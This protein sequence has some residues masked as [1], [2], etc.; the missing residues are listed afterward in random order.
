M[1]L[2]GYNSN[3][4]LSNFYLSLIKLFF[5][6]MIHSILRCFYVKMTDIQRSIWQTAAI[7]DSAKLFICSRRHWLATNLFLEIWMRWFYAW[8][9]MNVYMINFY[10][11]YSLS[12]ISL[13]A[14]RILFRHQ[15]LMQ[16]SFFF[17]T[18]WRP[19]VFCLK[20]IM[21]IE[22][23]CSTH[24]TYKLTTELFKYRIL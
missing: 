10:H 17:Y 2:R 3:Y 13:A 12:G 20:T 24:S 15:I 22:G 1:F 19:A 14:G 21:N 16:I 11:H 4:N 8:T 7:L 18:F 9:R 23:F 6:S 5:G